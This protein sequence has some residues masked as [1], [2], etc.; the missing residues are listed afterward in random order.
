[1]EMDD[2]IPVQKQRRKCQFSHHVKIAT[3]I[4]NKS[5]PFRDSIY[6]TSVVSSD[7]ANLFYKQGN[8]LGEL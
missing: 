5:R 4:C 6:K 3:K 1:M 7:K 8:A 2:G